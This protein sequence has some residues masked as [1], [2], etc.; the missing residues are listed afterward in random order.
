M[1]P[2]TSAT[3]AR[4]RHGGARL[5]MLDEAAL[6]YVGRKEQ[7]NDKKWKKTQANQF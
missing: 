2:S 6:G 5:A 3:S 1:V 4:M 7:I